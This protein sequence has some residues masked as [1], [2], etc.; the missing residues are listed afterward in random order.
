M[1][2]RMSTASLLMA[3]AV[4]IAA[5]AGHY[6]WRTRKDIKVGDLLLSNRG[7]VTVIAY[8]DENPSAVIDSRLVHRGDVIDG[9]KV[10]G[11]YKDKV[12]FDRNGT[13]WSQKIRE[14]PAKG[15]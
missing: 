1:K 10:V 8:N 11:I 9:V 3:A 2:S 12:E 7:V 5:M 6:L 14:R 13:K 15:W 4:I